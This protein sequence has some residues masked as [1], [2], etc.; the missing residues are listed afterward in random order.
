MANLL[1][2][3]VRLESTAAAFPQPE[4][5]GR[6]RGLIWRRTFDRAPAGTSTDVIL[7]DHGTHS[8]PLKMKAGAA[9]LAASGTFENEE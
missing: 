8:R 6:D 7:D 5:S 2:S 9:I 3:R 4:E 1:L